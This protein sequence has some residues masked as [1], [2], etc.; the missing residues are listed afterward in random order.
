MASLADQIESYLVRLLQGS[1]EG[2]VEVRRA[3]LAGQFE[4]VPSQI[5]YVLETR[6]APERGYVIESRRGGGG[7]IRIIRLSYESPGGLLEEIVAGLGASI[8]EPRALHYVRLLRDRL[9]IS[10]REA[11]IMASA[12]SAAAR[13]LGP[14]QG[15]VLRAR[16]LKAM[17]IAVLRSLSRRGESE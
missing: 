10:G 4:C 6:F 11:A 17:L 8:D 3:D 9:I 13:G 12:L 5:N 7:Y 16:V 2:I 15:G 14:R 1:G